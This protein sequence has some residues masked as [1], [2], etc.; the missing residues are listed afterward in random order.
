MI[1]GK[2]DKDFVEG[3]KQ[4][5]LG[6]TNDI[7]FLRSVNSSV[8]K[9]FIKVS[10]DYDEAVSIENLLNLSGLT[11]TELSNITGINLMEFLDSDESITPELYNTILRALFKFFL[12]NTGG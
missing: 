9:N 8:I 11:V 1:L 2:K 10:H 12:E 5:I 7:N 6:L 4:N 3:L